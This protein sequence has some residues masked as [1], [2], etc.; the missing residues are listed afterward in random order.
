MKQSY[1]KQNRDPNV[2]IR[3]F[4]VAIYVFLSFYEFFLNRTIGALT[5]YYVFIIIV[6]IMLTANKLHVKS[7]HYAIVGWLI[8]KFLSLA[9]TPSYNV[10]GLRGFSEVIYVFLLVSLTALEEQEKLLT[11]LQKSF[12]LCSVLFGVL[13]LFFNGPYEGVSSR[14]VLTLFGVQFEPNN[15]VAFL[16]CGFALSLHHILFEKKNT[17]LHIMVI[18]INAYAILITGSRAGLLTLAAVTLCCLLMV[19][20]SEARKSIVF[21]VILVAFVIIVP[22]IIILQYLPE[23]TFD[24]LFTFEDYEGGSERDIMWR[25]GINILSNPINLLMGIGWGGYGGEGGYNSLHNTFL[26][27][28]CDSGIIG[29]SVLFGPIAVSIFKMLKAKNPL[30]LIIF[31]SAMVPSFFIEA[32]NKRFFWNALIYVFVSYNCYLKELP[33]TDKAKRLT[34]R[35]SPQSINK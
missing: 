15:G 21:R 26:S 2:S 33:N 8:Y 27:V 34:S 3:L 25:Y 18:I 14:L 5:K 4:L 22:C 10:F 9:W 16:M 20:Q 29:F 28:L 30:P 32:I 35:S 23:I 6:M 13:S 7:Y 11:L 31:I 1:I 24:R 19:N 17:F 12:W